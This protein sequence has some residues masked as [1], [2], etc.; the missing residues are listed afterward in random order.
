MIPETI[1][2]KS[3][4]E[5]KVPTRSLLSNLLLILFS[6]GLVAWGFRFIQSKL[7]TVTSVDAVI[8]GVLTDIKAPSEGTVSYKAVKTGD[9]TSRKQVVFVLKNERV[10]KLQVQEINTRLNQQQAQLERAQAQLDRQLA[11]MQNLAADNKQQQVLVNTEAKQA[12]LQVMADIQSAQARY[13]LAKLNHKR[14]ASLR[15]QGV[16]S[17]E[18]LDNITMEMN[19]RQAEVGSV[20]SRLNALRADREAAKRGLSLSKTRS[21]Y[22]P[23]IRL[24]EMQMQVADQREVVANLRQSIK[25]TK[26]ELS[27]ATAD[28]RRKQTIAIRAPNSGVIW[29]LQAQRGKLVQQGETLGQTLDCEKRWVDVVVDEQALRSLL[30]GMAATVELYGLNSRILQGRV[31]TIRSGLGR[32]AAGEDVAI[33]LDEN[34]RRN[35]QVRVEF[36][37]G[38]DKGSPGVFCYV[39]YTGRVTFQIHR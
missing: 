10:S 27:Q 5:Y 8:N 20:E 29:R 33:P 26:A 14:T 15:A 18:A 36:D 12:E 1:F 4:E 16:V 24:Q 13:Q 2:P 39:G 28:W 32:L 6:A 11:L 9:L 31:S 34:L 23:G 21:N 3:R 37:P 30:P 19:Q 17:Q 25:D 22:D 7:T 38:T 35:T